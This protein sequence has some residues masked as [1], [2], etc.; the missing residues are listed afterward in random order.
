MKP[1]LYS[2]SKT[3]SPWPWRSRRPSARS[4]RRSHS[5][6]RRPPAGSALPADIVPGSPLADVVKLLQAGVDVST[7]KSYVLNAQSAFNLDAD[8]ILS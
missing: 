3:W 1:L 5:R 7:I 2:Y 4:A 8:K 6:C